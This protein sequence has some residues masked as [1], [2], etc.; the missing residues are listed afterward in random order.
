[1]ECSQLVV[2]HDNERDKKDS[3]RKGNFPAVVLES[4]CYRQVANGFLCSA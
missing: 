4:Q 1:M 2:K 3:A